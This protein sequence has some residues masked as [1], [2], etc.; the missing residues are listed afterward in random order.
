MSQE[1]RLREGWSVAAPIADYGWMDKW[2]NGGCLTSMD[3][4]GWI[5]TNEQACEEM[6]RKV[7]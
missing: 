4:M 6:G 2:M 7:G 3:R 1:N 5:E